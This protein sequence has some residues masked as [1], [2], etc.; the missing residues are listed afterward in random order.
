MNRAQL[1]GMRTMATVIVQQG[2]YKL[3]DRKGRVCMFDLTKDRA[4]MYRRYLP[5]GRIE[6]ME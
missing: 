3:L 5:G 1:T 4:E 2:R 6:R